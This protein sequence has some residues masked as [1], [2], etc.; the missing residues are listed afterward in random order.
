[1]E[2]VAYDPSVEERYVSVVLALSDLDFNFLSQLESQKDASIADIMD[3]LCLD[4]PFAETPKV[5]RSQPAY[6]QLLLPIHQKEDNV[7]I[8]ETS[9]Y[10]PLTVVHDRIQKVK[11]CALSHRLPISEAMGALVDPLSFENLI[12]EASTSGVLAAAATTIA[13]STTFAHTSSVPPI[14]VTDYGVL[15]TEAQPEA[16]HSPK[17]IFEQETLETSPKHP[18]TRSLIHFFCWRKF[19]RNAF[20]D[21][22]SYP[23]ILGQ[24]IKPYPSG[25]SEC[26]VKHMAPCWHC[27]AFH[28]C[29]SLEY[30]Q[31]ILR[32]FASVRALLFKVS[33]FLHGDVF[34]NGFRSLRTGTLI[35]ALRVC[36][37]TLSFTSRPVRYTSFPSSFTPSL[38]LGDSDLLRLILEKTL[39]GSG[40]LDMLQERLDLLPIPCTPLMFGVLDSECCDTSWIF[41][42]LPNHPSKLRRAF[43]SFSLSCCVFSL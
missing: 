26:G 37:H 25:S 43:T 29:S 5:S 39:V 6:E 20:L 12:G 15:D 17:F 10:D 40:L 3:S 31:M 42:F 35:T 32:V 7:V 16:S 23:Q 33:A 21:C 4:A 13:L 22:H 9:L 24:I 11:E 19:A 2:V 28:F 1:A 14:F 36:G 8:G 18:A 30:F 34:G 41:E 27:P 38:C